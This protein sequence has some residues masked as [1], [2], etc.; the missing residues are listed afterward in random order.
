[1]IDV[2]TSSGSY[3]NLI[4]GMFNEKHISETIT[5]GNG[6]SMMATKV[7]S[8]KRCVIQLN[9]STLNVTIN[10]VNVPDLCVNHFSIN[11]ALKNDKQPWNSYLLD[12]G[13]SIYHF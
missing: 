11:K 12:K 6:N 5:V 3:C 7:G 10:K 9:G 13:I 1:L 4:E 2:T 8:L